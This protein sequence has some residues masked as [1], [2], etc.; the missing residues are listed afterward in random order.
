MNNCN[1]NADFQELELF[2]QLSEEYCLLLENAGNF[3]L[4]DI[5][6]KLLDILPRLYTVMYTRDESHLHSDEEI[7]PSVTEELWEQIRQTLK[8]R[9]NRYDVYPEIFD[10]RSDLEGEAVGCSISEDLADIYQDIKNF[11]V[12]YTVAAEEELH[13]AVNTCRMNFET[14]WGQRLVN[15]LRAL[16]AIYFGTDDLDELPVDTERF[17]DYMK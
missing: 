12:V 7:R 6:S 5:V 8:S 15:V 11:M 2:S 14:Y 13:V 1:H 17:D 9:F 16:H 10:S 3:T 4:K